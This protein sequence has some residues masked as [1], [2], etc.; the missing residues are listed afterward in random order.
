MSIWGD[1]SLTV[2]NVMLAMD[3]CPVAE[4]HTILKEVLELMDAH[5]LGVVCIVDRAM[6]LRG[7]MTEGDIRRKL[8]Q[9]QKPF[10]ALMTDDVITHAVTSPISINVD[11]QLVNALSLMGEKKIWDLPVVDVDKKL[12]GLL[13]LHQAIQAV[14]ESRKR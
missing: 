14:L 9:V 2:G 4:E 8:L 6:C 5:R 3:A 12:V 10:A 7:I 11:A 1:K 13:H